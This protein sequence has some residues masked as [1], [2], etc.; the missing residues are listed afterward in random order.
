MESICNYFSFILASGNSFS[1]LWKAFSQDFH[2]FLQVEIIILSDIYSI[3]FYFFFPGEIIFCTFCIFLLTVA[4]FFSSEKR[5]LSF[6]IFRCKWKTVF[7]LVK[8]IFSH[9]S[10]IFSIGNHFPTFWKD[11]SKIFHQFFLVETI[12]L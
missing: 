12:F 10:F 1:V 3:L 7:C 6:F 9:F 11:P 4:I 8:S 2:I 5:F